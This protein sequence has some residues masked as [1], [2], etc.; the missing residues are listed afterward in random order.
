MPTYVYQC[1]KCGDEFELWQSISDDP[2]KK[3]SG[4]GGKVTKV[5]QPVGIVLKGSG[6]YKNDSRSSSGGAK[7]EKRDTSSSETST[8]E[9]KPAKAETKSESKPEKK[10]DTS[11]GSKT[12]VAS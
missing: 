4:C 8:S 1:S 9:S 7:R 6:F 10:S 2:L 3:H 11:S 12:A 5:L